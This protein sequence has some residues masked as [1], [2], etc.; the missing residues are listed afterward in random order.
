[1]APA[2]RRSKLPALAALVLGACALLQLPGAFVS[3]P[4]AARVE[5]AH[6][7][8]AAVEERRVPVDALA[9]G[10]GAGLLAAEPAHAGILFDEVIPYASVT[11]F[12]ILWGIVLGFVLLRLQE[13][14]PE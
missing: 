12:V 7:A 10:A 6:V 9:L 11:S 13:A 3:S 4:A 14:F 8:E 5:A 1:M 2:I